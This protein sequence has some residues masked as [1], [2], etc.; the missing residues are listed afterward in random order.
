MRARDGC[1]W[2]TEPSQTDRRLLGMCGCFASFSAIGLLLFGLHKPSHLDIGHMAF[3]SGLFKTP[4]APAVFHG[5][6]RA[7]SLWQLI[8]KRKPLT[9]KNRNKDL[10]Y[11]YIYIPIYVYIYTYIYIHTYIEY[12]YKFIYKRRMGAPWRSGELTLGPLL[13]EAP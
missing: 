7:P 13:S 11:I 9:K 3:H 8:S 5:E 1:V 4:R 10:K 6:K 12:R 2:E